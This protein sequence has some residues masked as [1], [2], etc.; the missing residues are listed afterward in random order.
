[1]QSFYQGHLTM[2]HRFKRR[3]GKKLSILVPAFFL[4][5]FLPFLPVHNAADQVFSRPA[6]SDA[7]EPGLRDMIGQMLLVGFG[8]GTEVTDRLYTD[9]TEHNLGGV[10]LYAY[11]VDGPISLRR[12][13]SRL[14]WTDRC[15]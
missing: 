12:N 7:P 10:I 6:V 4:V 15:G 2:L 13:E 14:I 11:N 3:I 9:I 5:L 1:M 8:P